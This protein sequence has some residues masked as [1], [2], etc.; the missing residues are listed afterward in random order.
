MHKAAGVVVPRPGCHRVVNRAVAAFVAERPA[1]N[2]GMVF[3][4]P[5]HARDAL[6]TSHVIALIVNYLRKPSVR[7]EVC[8]R[9]HIQAKFVGKVVQVRITRVMRGSH[10]VDV[11][12]FHGLEVEAH[13]FFRHD[14]TCF[15]VVIV[16]ID[17]LN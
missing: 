9:N 1:N 2:A 5:Y 4:A 16:T 7:L 17:T 6:E 10:G 14:T 3:I 11:V 12:A 13:G 8:F 15:V